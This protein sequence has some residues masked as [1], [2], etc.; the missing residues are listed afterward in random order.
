MAIPFEQRSSKNEIQLDSL[1]LKSSLVLDIRKH[2]FWGSFFR[3]KESSFFLFSLSLENTSQ[4]FQPF[5]KTLKR[6]LSTHVDSPKMDISIYC[7]SSQIEMILI[8]R[9]KFSFFWLESK[10]SFPRKF[11]NWLTKSKRNQLMQIHHIA[12]ISATGIR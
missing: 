4:H 12:E 10:L 11:S 1:K 6:V 5:E 2:C 9:K 8:K 3:K 7:K